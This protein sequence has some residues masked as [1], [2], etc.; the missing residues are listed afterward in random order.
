MISLLFVLL[1]PLIA[2]VF[3]PI[4]RTNRNLFYGVSVII[5]LVSIYLSFY[6]DIS[7]KF[8]IPS[9]AFSILMDKYSKIFLILVSSTWLISIIYSYEYTKY[10]FHKKR[11]KF[12][13]FLNIIL[14]IAMINACAGNLITLFVFYLIG[15][16]LTYPL[17][18]FRNNDVSRQSAKGFLKQT[19]LPSLF[20]FLPAIVITEYLIG[21]VSFGDNTTLGS[22]HINPIIGG[23]LLLMFIIGIS[24]NSV[25]PFHLWLPNTNPAP[26]PVSGLIHSVATVKTGSIALIKIA[27]YI[28]GLDYIRVLTSDFFT[29]GWLTYL[30]GFTSL[31]TAYRALKT[32]D[33]KQRFA[34]STVGQLSYIILAILIGTPMGIMAATLHIVT[35]GIAKSCLFYVAG[36]YNTVYKTVSAKEI[37]KIMPYTRFIAL[38]IAICGLSIT[39]FPFL[40]GYY[41][42]DLM[43]VEEW[44]AHYYS[45]AIFLLLG[46]II[47][48]FYIIGPVKNAFRK[49]D[50]A[51]HAKKIPLSML[52]TFVISIVLI[53]S[54]NYYVPY[55]ILLIE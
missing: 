49:K 14:S 18:N 5:S 35:H 44:H 37:G 52:L 29:G 51:Y 19:I 9:I 45:S 47:N 11:I 2:L 34:F 23:I 20:I 53:I 10:N 13:I 36:F 41:S 4:K 3:V 38:V 50:P 39:G 16:P 7:L 33:L 40:A 43:L 12:F 46:S 25:F 22:H 32:D 48:I 30:C 26:A 8:E 28:F 1:A 27:V 54:S 17:I 31:Y 42:K 21:H 15:I 6:I 55:L 24:K